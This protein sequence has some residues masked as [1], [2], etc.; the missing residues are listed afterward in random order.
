MKH[1]LMA[2]CLL[3]LTLTSA[4]AQNK[5]LK[6]H[7]PT[8][9]DAPYLFLLENGEVLD[10]RPYNDE[11][12]TELKLKTGSNEFLSQI[13]YNYFT[14]AP[15]GSE[16]AARRASVKELLKLLPYT[17][18]EEMYYQL[19]RLVK[20]QDKLL[21]P[22]LEKLSRESNWMNQRYI[23]TAKSIITEDKNGYF[24]TQAPYAYKSKI[25][26]LFQYMHLFAQTHP[27]DPRAQTLLKF[28]SH[29]ADPKQG[30][31]RMI[32][33]QEE[34]LEQLKTQK[35]ALVGHDDSVTCP[36]GVELTPVQEVDRKI[37]TLETVLAILKLMPQKNF[38]PTSQ[39][40]LPLL[41]MDSVEYRADGADHLRLSEQ[42]LAEAKAFLRAQGYSGK[43]VEELAADA[44]QV[45]T[46]VDGEKLEHFSSGRQSTAHTLKKDVTVYDTITET[47]TPSESRSDI[48]REW[49]GS[50]WTP[51]GQEEHFYANVEV[52]DPPREIIGYK[53]GWVGSAWVEKRGRVYEEDFDYDFPIYG[54][55]LPQQRQVQVARQ[56]PMSFSTVKLTGIQKPFD[57]D[58]A[59]KFILKFMSEELKTQYPALGRAIENV[60]KE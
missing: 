4:M 2:G 36:I 12:K 54:N 20:P 34:K 1:F 18:S 50:A 23:D 58:S 48:V 33:E 57:A 29:L 51:D 10:V 41:V 37:K 49:A 25:D 22:L 60:L 5:L 8:S 21:V 35:E 40:G 38:A 31:Q 44:V 53:N 11:D 39:N 30:I 9:K 24:H 17:R 19:S 46:G 15:A 14:Q 42:K 52:W 28:K 27:N 45:A 55:I 26:H 6:N 3:G 32:E 47:Y 56:E 13:D 16:E 43:V 59:K 7:A